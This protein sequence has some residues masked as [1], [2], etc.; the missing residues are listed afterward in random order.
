MLQGKGPMYRTCPNHMVRALVA[1][2]ISLA[3][4]KCFSFTFRHVSTIPNN[5][6]CLHH[7]KHRLLNTAPPVLTMVRGSKSSRTIT[8]DYWRQ[9]TPVAQS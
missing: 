1:T 6:R 4:V 9:H 2:Y 7:L 3:S 8:A 5:L